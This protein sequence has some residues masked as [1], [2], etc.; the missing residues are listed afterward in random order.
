MGSRAPIPLCQQILRYGFR[1]VIQYLRTSRRESRLIQPF[2]NNFNMLNLVFF[3]LAS[4]KLVSWQLGL[5][6]LEV[7]LGLKREMR[8]LNDLNKHRSIRGF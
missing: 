2:E 5:T 8:L 1:M 4:C 3:E 6:E 7:R